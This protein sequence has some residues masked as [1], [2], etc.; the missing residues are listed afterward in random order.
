MA[1]LRRA[2]LGFLVIF[3]LDAA[4]AV[5]P[6]STDAIP[7]A[8]SPESARRAGEGLEQITISARKREERLQDAPLSVSAFSATAL[9]NG[10]VLRA[11]DLTR[12]T[13]NLK[14]EVTPGL[15]NAAAVMIRG[16]GN[17]D[18][19]AT[20]DNGVGV[21][22]D[23]IYLARPQGQLFGLGDIQRVEVLRGPQ[24][25]LFGRNTIGGA[26]NIIT[27]K[28]GNDFA[29]EGSVRTGNLNLFQSRGSV[30]IP[31]VPEMAALMLSFQTITRDG[32]T[33]NELLG[34]ETDDRRSLAGRAALR[35]IPTE[36]LEIVLT[37]EQ[38]RAHAAGRGGE[39]RFSPVAL[40]T[41]PAA[42]VQQL[43]R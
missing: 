37:G 40:A 27:R 6:D 41:A 25:T 22:V 39:C 35:V 16:I 7:Q 12:F 20:R 32:Y 15:Q 24:G 19:I 8:R 2:V 3:A 1:A 14:L 4:G 17:A 29:V 21:Y 43:K 34:Q 11:D 18:V 38:T 10:D 5:P 42:Q 26:I 36:R 13:P 31:L 30:N 28:P 9:R 33:K 23:G